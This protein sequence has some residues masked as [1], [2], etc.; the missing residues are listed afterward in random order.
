MTRYSIEPRTG[1][2]SKG[3]GILLFERKYRQQL[4][5]VGLD[6][7]KTVSK[8]TVH[9]PAEATGEFIGNKI[10]NKIVKTK[11]AIDGNP[12]NF[13]EIIIPPETREEILNQLRNVL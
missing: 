13:I 12:R 2:Y 6:D 11:H 7:L 10:A 8:K 4:L 1:K 5:D 9:K 3:H